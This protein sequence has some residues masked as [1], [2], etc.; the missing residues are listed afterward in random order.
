MSLAF[1]SKSP[2]RSG[3][4]ATRTSGPVSER[5]AF[6][7]SRSFWTSVWASGE[8]SRGEPSDGEVGE[9]IVAVDRGQGRIGDGPEEGGLDRGGGDPVLDPGLEEVLGVVGGVAEEEDVARG[10]GRPLVIGEGEEVT[11]GLG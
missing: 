2:A 9:E 7:K 10:G 8:G 3:L 11:D 1:A 4:S 6:S 5:P